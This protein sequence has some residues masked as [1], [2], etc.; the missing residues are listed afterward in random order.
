MYSIQIQLHVQYTNTVTCTVYKYSYMYSIQI[1]LHVQYTNTVTC[2]VYKYSYMYSIQIQLHVQYTN[3]VTCT[4]YKYSYMYS[5]QIIKQYINTV[6][7]YRLFSSICLFIPPSLKE[8][9]LY[10][11]KL[12]VSVLL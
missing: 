2:T 1:Q 10:I 5:I 9:N 7:I 4:V 12:P 8:S 6:C 11:D 3:T